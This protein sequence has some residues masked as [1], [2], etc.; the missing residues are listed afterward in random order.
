M[1]GGL[2]DCHGNV[3]ECCWDCYV[4][5]DTAQ[6]TDLT[7]VSSGTRHVYRSGGWNDFAK[8]MRS[9][10]RAAGK[11]DMASFNLGVRLVR[12]ADKN[13]AV[14]YPQVKAYQMQ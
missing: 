14:R 9:T 5:Y 13:A 8:N 1:Q 4:T 11:A 2:Y 10:C 6:N 12:N 3:N 7:G